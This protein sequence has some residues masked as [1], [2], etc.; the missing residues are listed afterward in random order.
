MSGIDKLNEELEKNKKFIGRY[1]I[2]QRTIVHDNNYYNIIDDF[3]QAPDIFDNI[4]YTVSEKKLKLWRK[5][6]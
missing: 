4:N 2:K 5:E 6:Y 1:I 3:M